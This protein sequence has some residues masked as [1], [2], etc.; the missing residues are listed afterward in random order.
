[1]DGFLA[2]AEPIDA[3]DPIRPRPAPSA[4]LLSSSPSPDK[5]FNLP[6]IALVERGGCDF[7]LKVYNVQKANF[8]GAIVYN[9]VPN[10]IFAMGGQNCKCT[11]SHKLNDR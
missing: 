4:V 11:F 9:T 7:D 10:E 6:Y 8:S 3:C 1:M 5:L 2:I